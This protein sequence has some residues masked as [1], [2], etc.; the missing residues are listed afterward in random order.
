MV[1]LIGR[2][3]RKRLPLRYPGELKHHQTKH[4]FL[5]LFFTTKWVFTVIPQWTMGFD[6]AGQNVHTHS[7]IWHTHTRK[8]L[9]LTGRK[10]KTTY[11]GSETWNTYIVRSSK[12][13]VHKDVHHTP[14]HLIFSSPPPQPPLTLCL[15][16]SFFPSIYSPLPSQ[17]LKMASEVRGRE[18]SNKTPFPP[19]TVQLRH[20]TK[21]WEATT[22]FQTSMSLFSVILSLSSPSCM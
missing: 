10:Q 16:P 7:H 17:T 12:H 22:G 18:G 8:R 11:T 19:E 3:K 21:R 15:I 4:F 14:T 2:F 1:H 6:T 13:T 20:K 5:F 9:T